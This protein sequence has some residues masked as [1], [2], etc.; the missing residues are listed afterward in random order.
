M[1]G[2]YDFDQSERAV[3]HFASERKFSC[4]VLL[5]ERTCGREGPARSSY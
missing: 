2:T 3:A 1:K 4:E 5:Q